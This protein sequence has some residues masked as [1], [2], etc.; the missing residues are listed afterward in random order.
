MGRKF[1]RKIK[2]K[3]CGPQPGR[4]VIGMVIEQAPLEDELGDVLDKALRWRAFTPAQAAARA[5]TTEEALRDALDYRYDGLDEASVMRLAA[6]LDLHEAGLV[7]H[8]HG[9]YPVPRIAGLP[10]CLHSLRSPHGTGTANAYIVSDCRDGDGVMFD[11]GP[12]STRLRRMWPPGVERLAGIFI[13]HAESEHIGGL[14]EAQRLGG[15]GSVFGPAGIGEQVKNG[16]GLG[17]GAR[18]ELAMYAVEVL[19]TPGHCEAHNAYVVRARTAAGR[20]AP[21]LI[22]GDLLFAGSVGGAYFCARKEREQLR[23]IFEGL[24]DETVVAPGHGP[25]TTLG[26]ERRF[27]PFAP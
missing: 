21:L 10:F 26:H 5:G 13:T 23:R 27:N 11:T 9:R 4:Y 8:F 19:A 14:A 16:T 3:I 12:A 20:G 18:L 1:T 15:A 7:A 2:R 6:V 25:L 22:A 17:E 24:P